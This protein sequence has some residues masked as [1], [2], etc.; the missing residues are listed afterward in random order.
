MD[1]QEKPAATKI[2]IPD[3]VKEAVAE[4]EPKSEE[5]KSTKKKISKDTKTKEK[6]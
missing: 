4:D 6:K 1:S 5:A 3:E 2:E